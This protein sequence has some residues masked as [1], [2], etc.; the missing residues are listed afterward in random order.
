MNIYC[1]CQVANLPDESVVLCKRMLVVKI[2]V[3]QK[4]GHGKDSF[5]G[6]D[7]YSPH[8]PSVDLRECPVCGHQVILE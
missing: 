7:V 2:G 4:I 1:Q 5:T 8:Y 3:E 6:A